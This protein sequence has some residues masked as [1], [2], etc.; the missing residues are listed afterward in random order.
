MRKRHWLLTGAVLGVIFAGWTSGA[1]AQNAYFAV[2]TGASVCN[3]PPNAD[4]PLCRQG[5]LDGVGSATVLVTGPNSLCATIIV[6]KLN[7][8][9][10]GFPT[11]AHLHIG[12]ASYTGP[13]IVRLGVPKANG[14]GNPGTSMAC[15]NAVPTHI[16][17]SLH[18]NPEYFYIDV[19]GEGFP[20]GALRGQLF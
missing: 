8:T 9:D 11:G 12:Q 6:N 16:M 4:P 1:F 7:L 14:G 10:G 19:H 5:D 20:F 13:V 15:N 2:L 18:N 3:T 17:T